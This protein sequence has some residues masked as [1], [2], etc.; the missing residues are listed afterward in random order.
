MRQHLYLVDLALL[1]QSKDDLLRIFTEPV[2]AKKTKKT[3]MKTQINIFRISCFLTH[4]KHLLR[5]K[6]VFT[7]ISKIWI[8]TRSNNPVITTLS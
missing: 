8:H 3:A 4:H 2:Y 6:K 1:L 5:H 7:G